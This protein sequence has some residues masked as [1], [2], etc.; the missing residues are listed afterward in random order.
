[1]RKQDIYLAILFISFLSFSFL[2]LKT[3]KVSG[4]T[5]SSS[6]SSSGEV[7]SEEL[8][9]SSSGEITILSENNS[10]SSSGI[11]CTTDGDCPSGVCPNGQT[12][13]AYT[14]QAETG[15][16]VQL[17]FIADP[18]QFLTSSSSGGTSGTLSNN[19]TGI[20][21]ARV[22]KERPSTS[23]SSGD[24]S[25]S[26]SSSSGSIE[27]TRKAHLDI[28][29]K[30]ASIISFKLCV[31]DGRLEGIV[32]QG[33]TI[34]TGVIKE[35]NVISENE[36]EFTAEGRND[37]TAMIY[38]KLTGDRQF[39]G[40]FVDGHEFIGRKLNENRGC[41]APGKNKPRPGLSSSS[42]SPVSSDC[43]KPCGNICCKQDKTCKITDPCMG[44]PTC[45]SVLGYECIQTNNF[46]GMSGPTSPSMD[47][48]GMDLPPTSMGNSMLGGTEIDYL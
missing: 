9:P 5:N 43:A 44:D 40:R 11:A 23:S 36:V 48:P 27:V 13:Q 25:S 24:I 10:S 31:K 15:T 2:S 6:S 35:Q 33:G 17:Q 28:G 46:P 34:L 14:C 41:L 29:N 47:G 16:C 4:Q 26:S 3:D 1:M 8:S 22:P 37:R 19:F 32:H 12:Y 21:K 45:T 30:G 38:L 39:V 18:C 7:T 20:W 42:G